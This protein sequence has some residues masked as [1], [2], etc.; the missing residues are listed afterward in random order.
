MPPD[1]VVGPGRIE[2]RLDGRA[3]GVATLV[4]CPQ[5]RTGVLEHVQVDD[6]HRGRGYGRI[7]ALAAFSRVDWA[8]FVLR[9]F[10]YDPVAAS[11]AEL[12]YQ[13][14]RV[15]GVFRQRRFASEEE[16]TQILDTLS[17]AG[18]D[19]E[20]LETDGWLYAHLYISRPAGAATELATVMNAVSPGSGTSLAELADPPPIRQ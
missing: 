4:V 18:M 7:L 19:P 10:S 11:L 3:V 1:E 14:A 6:E 12:G 20:G 9:M 16:Q 17:S 8:T 2:L 5:D 15:D 13:S